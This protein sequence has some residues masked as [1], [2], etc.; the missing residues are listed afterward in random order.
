MQG[1]IP[2]TAKI[3]VVVS[4]IAQYRATR[5]GQAHPHSHR[6]TTL[7]GRSGARPSISSVGFGVGRVKAVSTYMLFKEH[8]RLSISNFQSQ[9][10]FQNISYLAIDADEDLF[11]GELGD[12]D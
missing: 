12:G 10:L 11:A 7:C 1:S 6:S 4:G 3:T 5:Q 9:L 2:T 8:L